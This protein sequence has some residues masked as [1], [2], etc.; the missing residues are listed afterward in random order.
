MSSSADTDGVVTVEE[1]GVRVTK[2]FAPDEFPVPAIRFEIDSSHDEPV[3]VR[4]GETIP[5]SFPMD[6]VG[7]HPEYHSD[8]WTAFQNHRVEFEGTVDPDS[9]LVTVYGIRIDDDFDPEPFLTEP[10]IDEVDTK[11]ASTTEADPDALEEV[12]PEDRNEVVK[13]IL[14]DDSEELPGLDSDESDESSS[15]DQSIELDIDAAAE[16]VANQRGGDEDVKTDSSDPSDETT[17]E[18][19]DSSVSEPESQPSDEADDDT[20]D[21]ESDETSG[22]ADPD[23]SPSG[24][25]TESLTPTE[26]ASSLAT[27]IRSEEIDTDDLQTIRD[28]LEPTSEPISAVKVEHLQNRVEEVAAYSNALETFLEE[29]GTGAQVIERVTSELESIRSDIDALESELEKSSSSVDSVEQSVDSLTD[30]MSALESSVSENTTSIDT[31]ESRLDSLAEL[32]ETIESSVGELDGKADGLDEDLSSL[33][34]TVSAVESDVGSVTSDIESVTDDIEELDT[35]V[36]ELES[37]L[38]SVRTDV[39]DIVEWRAQLGSMF[40]E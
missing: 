32:T 10:T 26:V 38:E 16:R 27:A 24:E 14:S 7:F 1:S 40:S 33:E 34:T 18:F 15:D 5:E 4:L 23:P 12:I 39:S 30:T 20:D 28:A 8:Q 37:D 17:V 22:V 11:S 29:E 6:A 21:G 19:D 36:E 2:R 13:S 3:V 31:V 9:S 35:S 25:S